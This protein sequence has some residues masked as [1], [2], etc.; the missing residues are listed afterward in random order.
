M[1]IRNTANF[2]LRRTRTSTSLSRVA[3]NVPNF[4]PT[5]LAGASLCF[6]VT[7]DSSTPAFLFLAADRYAPTPFIL[8]DGI[9]LPPSVQQW[10]CPHVQLPIFEGCGIFLISELF[11]EA[12]LHFKRQRSIDHV[13]KPH[14]LMTRSYQIATLHSI[15]T[16]KLWKNSINRLR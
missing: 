6:P 11:Q 2:A 16:S 15:P 8:T 4:Q 12:K 10:T 1:L 5:I 13:L 7:T 9:I 14:H 3:E